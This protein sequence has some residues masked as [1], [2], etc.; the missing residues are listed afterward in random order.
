MCLITLIDID[1]CIRYDSTACSVHLSWIV[2]T[3]VKPEYRYVLLQNENF[4]D[5]SCFKAHRTDDSFRVISTWGLVWMYA[6]VLWRWRRRI[7]AGESGHSRGLQPCEHLT[8]TSILRGNN[9]KNAR[10]EGGGCQWTAC[11]WIMIRMVC[12][13]VVWEIENAKADFN[14]ALLG[15]FVL[16]GCILF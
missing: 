13:S 10:A 8:F 3:S 7:N 9:N 5:F 4:R 16:G 2:S 1:L 14:A 11:I 12:Q 15:A 6:G